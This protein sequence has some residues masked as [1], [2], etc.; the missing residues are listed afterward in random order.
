MP[1]IQKIETAYRRIISEIPHPE[2]LK[3]INE[4]NSIEPRAMS[5]FSPV[6]WDRAQGF[7]VW[8]AYGNK[9]IDF[10]SAVVLANAGHSNPEIKK[11]IIQQLETG[12]WHSYCNPSQVSLNTVMAI[13]SILPDHLDKVFLLTTGSEAVECAVKLIRIY[14]RKISNDKIY[15][16]SFFNSF[17]GRT[18][19][20]QSVGGFMD[21]Q[22]WMGI[23]PEGFVHI[24]YPECARC[25]WGRDKYEECGEECF[26]R[27]LKQLRKDG[28]KEDLFAGVIA[29]TFQGP[30]V[31]FMPQDYVK[32]L[33]EWAD[34]HKALLSFDEIQSGFGR[35]GKWFGFEHY[36]IKADLIIMGKGVTSC[37]PL[38]A[39]AGRGEIM[40]IPQHGEMSSTHTGNPLCCAAAIANIETIKKEKMVENAASLEKEAYESLNKLRGKYPDH[41]MAISGKGLAWAVYLLKPGQKELDIELGKKVTKKCMESGLL[42]LSTG[43]GTLKIAPPLCIN[44][45]AFLEGISVIEQSLA[46]S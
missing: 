4:L 40:D 29:E 37:L 17:H 23:K 24:P 31:A 7:Q 45:E 21:L 18:M 8:D 11:A 32:A 22:A 13:K 20:S 33:R 26:E 35:T 1:D 46:D 36:G 12:M 43:R 9:W 30:T 14:G 2:S 44:H 16:L 27:S 19:A 3:L 15:I 10:S 42:M 34:V 5:G 6:V 39:V 25:P 38:S 41:I 28:Y